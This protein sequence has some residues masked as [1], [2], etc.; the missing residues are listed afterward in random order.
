MGSSHDIGLVKSQNGL[1]PVMKMLKACMKNCRALQRVM[2][3]YCSKNYE[4]RS[5]RLPLKFILELRLL[6]S[7]KGISWWGKY[8]SICFQNTRCRRTY[9]CVCNS[10]WRIWNSC[11]YQSSQWCRAPIR[12][13]TYWP[14]DTFEAEQK[15]MEGRAKVLYFETVKQLSPVSTQHVWKQF[16]KVGRGVNDG[17]KR[18]ICKWYGLT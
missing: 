16:P 10:Y 7:D 14:K 12:A 13:G 17:R 2:D 11:H 8:D 3:K 15:E 5:R 4:Q 9:K 18:S 6:F 1:F